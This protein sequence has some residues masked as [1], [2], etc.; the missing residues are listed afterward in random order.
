MSVVVGALKKKTID[1]TDGYAH[2][3][4][5]GAGQYVKMIDNGIE[6][7][8]LQAYAEGYDIL[9]TSKKFK[10]FFFKAE[11]GIRDRN[12]TGVQTCALPISGKQYHRRVNN[13]AVLLS[14][15]WMDGTAR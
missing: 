9:H 11:D 12:V 8:M 10:L 5:A 14:C 1:Q 4:Q 2:M 7:E 6:Y 3:G 13:D 15:L